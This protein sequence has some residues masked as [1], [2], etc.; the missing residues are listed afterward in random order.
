MFWQYSGLQHHW[1][2]DKSVMLGMHS[3]VSIHKYWFKTKS[4]PAITQGYAHISA[5]DALWC[6][7]DHNDL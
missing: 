4:T 6:N 3:Q 5:N 7:M 1:W 2:W